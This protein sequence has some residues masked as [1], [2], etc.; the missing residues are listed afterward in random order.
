MS[1]L[2]ST[3]AGIPRNLEHFVSNPQH[4][5]YLYTHVLLEVF[6]A[7][8]A[9]YE[10]AERYIEYHGSLCKFALHPS[11]KDGLLTFSTYVSG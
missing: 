7:P 3:G 9:A 1:S 5:F 10:T 6:I 11:Q 4:G 8:L 2:W